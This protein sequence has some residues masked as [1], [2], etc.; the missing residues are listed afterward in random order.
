MTIVFI[1]KSSVWKG[2]RELTDYKF[3][4]LELLSEGSHLYWAL[5]S[6]ISISEA[7]ENGLT[8]RIFI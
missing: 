6:L 4:I 2:N 7:S 1:I 5:S 8:K 3:V